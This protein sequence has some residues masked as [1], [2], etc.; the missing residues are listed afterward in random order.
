MGKYINPSVVKAAMAALQVYKGEH[1]DSVTPLFDMCKT[2]DAETKAVF[3]RAAQ[4]LKWK[5][6]RS[7]NGIYENGQFIWSL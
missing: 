2:S 6:V 3:V 1:P 4:R 5:V 7:R